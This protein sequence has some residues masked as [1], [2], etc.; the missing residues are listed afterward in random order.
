MNI[1]AIDSAGEVLSA[2]LA[3]GEDVWYM[4]TDSGGRHSELLIECADSLCKSAG[5]SPHD[6]G[7]ALCMKGPGSFTGLRIGYST[8]KGLA[9]ALGIPFTAIPTLDCLAFPLSVWPGLVL[10]SMDAKK[11]CFFAALY[12][13]GERLTRYLDA[14]PETLAEEA[15]KAGFSGQEPLV[16]TGSGAKMLF[17]ALADHLP[18]EYMMIDPCFKRGRAQELLKI[19]GNGILNAVNDSGLLYLRKSDAELN[20]G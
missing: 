14:S 16:L 18:S 1:L 10:P 17:S 3:V 12:R 9:L 4:E 15:L 11:G 2:A 20:R 8:V 5:I 7:M 13:A 19:A 6:L